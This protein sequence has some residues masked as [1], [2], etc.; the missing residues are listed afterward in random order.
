M[1]PPP[2]PPVCRLAIY[3]RQSLAHDDEFSSCDAQFEICHQFITANRSKGWVW[4]G[5]RY[6]DAGQSGERLDR[7][8]LTQLLDDLRR[9]RVGGLV[10]HRIDRLSRKLI[11]LT[12]LLT[13]FRDRSIPLLIVTDP[14]LGTSATDMLVLNILGS[15]AEFEREMIRDRL[16]DTRAAMKRKGLRVAGKVPYGYTTD[17]HTKQLVVL[18]QQAK[19]VRAFFE[20]AAD[21]QTPTEIVTTANARRWLTNP[22]AAKP[23]GGRWTPRQV[24]DILANPIYQGQIHTTNGL[25]PGTHEAIIT[26]ETFERV[27]AMIASRRVSTT[28][29]G[30]GLFDWPL[31]G[32]VMCGRCGR[33]MST[34]VI[35]HCHLRYRHYRCRSHA[36]GRPPCKGVA[37]PAH[38]LE[39]WVVRELNELNPERFRDPERRQEVI[40]FR[41]LWGM[42]TERE[43]I[44]SLPAIV[45]QVCFDP[46]R[47]KIRLSLRPGGVG[48]LAGIIAKREPVT[49]PE[50]RPSRRER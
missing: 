11:D 31:R 43:R 45:E 41:S 14:A 37:T 13:E 23:S 25:A 16:A 38:E 46:N 21:G 1:S 28:P 50:P 48:A 39:Q 19:R 7:P 18:R 32:L 12:T 6:D 9:G 22:S 10:V 8:A 15:F 2:V 5:Q 33:T 44:E 17:P 35:H 47:S 20:W 27:R 40:D 36:G 34:S 4:C 3:T 29:H 26:M 42:L 24:A 49:Q 30:K